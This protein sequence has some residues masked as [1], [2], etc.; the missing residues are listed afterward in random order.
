M[1]FSLRPNWWFCPITVSVIGLAA[2]RC[3]STEPVKANCVNFLLNLQVE[4]CI[5]VSWQA[6]SFF[7]VFSLNTMREA[8]PEASPETSATGAGQAASAHT[9]TAKVQPSQHNLNSARI[10]RR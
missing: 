7:L 1:S 5:S 10:N 9:G 2:L 3:A 8:A 6:A 4:T